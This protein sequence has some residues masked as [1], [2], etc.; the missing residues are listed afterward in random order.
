MTDRPL[1]MSMWKKKICVGMG[2]GVLLAL[3]VFFDWKTARIVSQ[4]VS[5][6]K[7]IVIDS[8]HGGND[9]GKVGVCG[10][11]EKDINLSIAKKVKE[12]LKKKN[13]L[14]VMTREEDKG[15]YRETDRKK[16]IAD[17]KARVA[18]IEETNPDM[19]V[20]I[21]QNSFGSAGVK[22]AQV[23]YYSDSEEGKRMGEIMQET[24]KSVIHD[25]N[26]RKAK[27]NKSYYLLC[28]TKVP[29]VIVECGFLSN[30]DEEKL[31]SDENYQKKMA[32]AIVMGIEKSMI[33]KDRKT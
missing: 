6:K 23:F 18:L 16:K 15:L 1:F 3:A 29:L 11:L 30:P 13:Y 24:I 26:H 20:S 8:G 5:G 17:L 10:S 7:V 22:G 32:E 4:K 31:L 19:V 2:I 21:H 14:V 33:E 27:G 12:I 25:G 9:P 28:K